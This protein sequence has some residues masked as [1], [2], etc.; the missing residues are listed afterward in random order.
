MAI[1]SMALIAGGLATFMELRSSSQA[2]M[3]SSL[4]V[5]HSVAVLPFENLSHDPADEYLADGITDALITELGKVGALRI[6]SR[7]SS[8]RYRNTGKSL[9]DIGGD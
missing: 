9:P 4:S 5:A 7:I 3:T 6:I 1:S 2:Q 8:A